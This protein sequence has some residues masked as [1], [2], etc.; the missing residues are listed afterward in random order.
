MNKQSIVW[1]PRA[2]I[3]F[4][5]GVMLIYDSIVS[6]LRFGAGPESTADYPRGASHTNYTRVLC[7][8]FS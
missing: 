3:I 7:I 4:R 2:G 5:K 1:G 8:C 6:N